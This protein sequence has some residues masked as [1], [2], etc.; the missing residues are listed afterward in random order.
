MVG[1]VKCS[2]TK[3]KAVVGLS[4]N[5]SIYLSDP[6]DEEGSSRKPP[7]NTEKLEIPL[8]AAVLCK[9]R[10]IKRSNKL[11]ET[12]SD[13]K[14]SNKI[15]KQNMLAS[16]KLMNVPDRVPPKDHEDHIEEGE[17]GST[18]YNLVH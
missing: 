7:K 10:T 16:K 18:Y 6:D 11:R 9:L 4:R 5:R 12:Y 14:G 15:Q 13:I 1:H 17:R 2:S 3:G 8:E